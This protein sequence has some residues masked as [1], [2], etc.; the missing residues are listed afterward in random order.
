MPPEL[1]VCPFCGGA[2]IL[3]ARGEPEY[4]IDVHYVRCAGT[5]A[6]C[7]AVGAQFVSK[8]VDKQWDYDQAMEKAALAWNR[9]QGGG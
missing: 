5:N 7:R 6:S 4:G 9:R 3:L 2:A 8:R 1:K